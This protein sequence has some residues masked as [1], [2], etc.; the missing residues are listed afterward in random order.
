M[1]LANGEEVPNLFVQVFRLPSGKRYLSS[2]LSDGEGASEIVL[3]DIDRVEGRAS[4]LNK[5]S[6]VEAVCMRLL[7]PA[8]AT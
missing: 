6:C 5:S 1:G 3:R 4:C 7:A 8:R 2:V